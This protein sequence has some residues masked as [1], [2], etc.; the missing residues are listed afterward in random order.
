MKKCV[1]CKTNKATVP[2]RNDVP[3]YR[4]RVCVK[5]HAA[6]VA[7]LREQDDAEATRNL[8][9]E[10]PVSEQE[11]QDYLFSEI[12]KKIADGDIE[13]TDDGTD[14]VRWCGRMAQHLTKE[15]SCGN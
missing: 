5:C 2:D 15:D 3:R 11:I 14:L 9:K 6:R 12:N 7:L 1:E 10:T 4:I 13:W 8:F